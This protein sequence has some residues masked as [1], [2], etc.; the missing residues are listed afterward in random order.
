MIVL[1]KPKFLPCILLENLDHRK[2]T[3]KLFNKQITV[4]NKDIKLAKLPIYEKNQFM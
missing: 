1:L 3:V 4:E 2:S